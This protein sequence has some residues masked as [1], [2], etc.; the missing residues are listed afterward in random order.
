VHGRS[1]PTR[2][3][4]AKTAALTP[5]PVPPPSWR[6]THFSDRPTR[7]CRG[8][9]PSLHQGSHRLWRCDVHGLCRSG[10]R[11]GSRSDVLCMYDRL[12]TAASSHTR[13]AMVSGETPR[14]GR[15]SCPCVTAAEGVQGLQAL[16]PRHWPPLGACIKRPAL[17]VVHDWPWRWRATLRCAGSRRPSPPARHGPPG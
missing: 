10:V 2:S 8:R 3:T 16:S 11:K 13:M 14:Q 1:R 17:R 5:I 6:A 9:L 12:H 7:V 4:R 15:C